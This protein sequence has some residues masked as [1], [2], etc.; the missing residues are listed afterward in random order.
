MKN[1]RRLPYLLCLACAGTLFL[2]ACG[3]P[4]STGA[5][6]IDEEYPQGGFILHSG[7]PMVETP[8]GFYAFKG[9]YLYYITPDLQKSTVLCGKPECTHNTAGNDLYAT[10]D[11]N[12]FF[13]DPQIAYYD[14]SLYIT[15]LNYNTEATGLPMAVYQ[16]SMDGSE[17]KLLLE[18]GQ[19]I[20]GLCIYKGNM[21]VADIVYDET[22]KKDRI[23]KI[24]MEN[25]TDVK[26]IFETNDYPDS[27]L[28]R[29]ECYGDSCYFFFAPGTL[30][31]SFES[32][33]VNL[34]NGESTLLHKSDKDTSLLYANDYG[35]II[36]D[37]NVTHKNELGD[38][39]WD[40]TY[41]KIAPG[42][43]KAVPLTEEDFPLLAENPKLENIDDTYVYFSTM[44]YLTWSEKS[45]PEDASIY[46]CTY[47]GEVA[48]TIPLSKEFEG[49]VFYALP[50][51]DDYL[52]VY[53]QKFTEGIP[54]TRYYYA[55]KAEFGNGAVVQLKEIPMQ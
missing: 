36:E 53:S 32:L 20:G 35:C 7:S 11:C 12:A 23:Q 39:L 1:A 44:Y 15:S 41:Y 48:A 46:A 51:T 50:G 40:S 38:W 26:T 27:T 6:D 52:F 30:D 28:N 31:G 29:F 17:R 2:S 45:W 25:P 16:V 47:D 33:K 43:T 42:D 24:S 34:E 10:T 9:N 18:C 8:E 37:Q 3:G 13:E 54:E 4:Q 21:Y 5:M 49:C 55:P 14:G 19:F 22:G